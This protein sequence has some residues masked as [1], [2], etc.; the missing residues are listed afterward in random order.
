MKTVK[1]YSILSVLVIYLISCNDTSRKHKNEILDTKKATTENTDEE[2]WLRKAKVLNQMKEG[3]TL[4]TRDPIFTKPKSKTNSSSKYLID[5]RQ[6]KVKGKESDFEY[7]S[8]W[9]KE[10]Y[11]ATK[12][13][14]TQSIN[15]KPNCKVTRQGTYSPLSVRYIGN[16]SYSVKFYCEFDCKQ[17][18]NNPSYYWVE[19][20]YQGN[21]SWSG[22]LIKQ[23]LVE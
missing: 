6:N 4:I 19:V 17:G 13:Y 10:A 8:Y 16:R 22:K 3:E 14:I 5:I 20:Y 9:R 15:K 1:L 18:Y 23:K 21:N 12:K 7:S 2:D 11:K